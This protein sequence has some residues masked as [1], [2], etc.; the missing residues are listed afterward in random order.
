MTSL[1]RIILGEGWARGGDPANFKLRVGA[2]PTRYLSWRYDEIDR[3]HPW[4][5][6]SA[7]AGWGRVRGPRRSKFSPATINRSC[8]E[9]VR[10]PRNLPRNF[11]RVGS[12]LSL[13]DYGGTP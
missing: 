7:R 4:F 8:T 9:P 5:R 3:L 11:N 2:T 13:I 1:L 12:V 6:V 10:L